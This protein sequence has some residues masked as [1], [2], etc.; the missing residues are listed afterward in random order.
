MIVA[1]S[2]PSGIGKGFIKMAIMEANPD[3]KEA[4]W[5][6]TRNLR[7]GE[8]NRASIPGIEFT[9]ME[10]T[11]R[12]VLVQELF[13]NRYGI[14]RQ[15]LE[16]K[17]GK[18]LTEIHPFVV[19]KAKEIN[20]NIIM[21]GIVTDDLG[22]LRE[23]LSERRKTETPAEIERR[24]KVAESEIEFIREHHDKFDLV[25]NIS[26][27]TETSIAKTMQTVFKIFVEKELKRGVKN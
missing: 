25:V 10:H 13:G 11:G 8:K 12:L 2:G 9:A 22:L 14:S 3:V 23:R 19:D 16:A 1:L 18:V 24:L 15:D 7:P 4:V 17:E 5:Y 6:T 20:P 26:R 21:I 27:K